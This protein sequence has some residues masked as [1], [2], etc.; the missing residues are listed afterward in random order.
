MGSILFLKDVIVRSIVE[1]LMITLGVLVAYPII[2]PPPHTQSLVNVSIDVV[3]YK[4]INLNALNMFWLALIVHMD[5]HRMS[6]FTIVSGF[7]DIYNIL[8]ILFV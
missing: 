7:C 3:D 8:C 4:G 2:P 5:K 6:L 1:E